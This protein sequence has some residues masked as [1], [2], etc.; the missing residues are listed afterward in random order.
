MLNAVRPVG[1]VG[2]ILAKWQQLPMCRLVGAITR[3]FGV[4][5]AYDAIRCR[6]VVLLSI[7][8]VIVM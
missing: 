8:D 1:L 7:C 4:S 2:E 3:Q 5:L 6:T